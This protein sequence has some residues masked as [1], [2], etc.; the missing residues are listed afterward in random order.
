MLVLSRHNKPG[1]DTIVIIIPPSGVEQ[2]IE[3]VTNEIRRDKVRLG[4]V[5]KNNDIKFWRK[6]LIDDVE[7]NRKK[8]SCN[9]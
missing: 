1:L 2:R 7:A 4:L 5:T 9:D 8:E 6:E 3:I